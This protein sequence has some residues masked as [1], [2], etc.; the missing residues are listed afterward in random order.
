MM[1]E[2]IALGATLCADATRNLRQLPLRGSDVARMWQGT[3][4]IFRR[5][6]VAD[7]F[8]YLAQDLARPVASTIIQSHIVG[9]LHVYHCTRLALGGVSSFVYSPEAPVIGQLTGVVA[10]A[11]A[12]S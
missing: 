5:A 6:G 4:F 7:V 1:P 11:P 12:E 8:V 2:P 10:A 3:C 9:V